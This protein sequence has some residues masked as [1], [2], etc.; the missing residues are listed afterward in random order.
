[1]QDLEFRQ[2]IERLKLRSPIEVIVGERISELKKK[3]ALYQARCPF[4]EER[5]PSFTVDPR[6][7][8]WHCWGACGE[9]G[10]VIS[11]VE[12]FD[13]VSFMDAVRLLAQ[14]AGEELPDSMF[15]RRSSTDQKAVDA[16]YDVLDRA[17]KLYRRALSSDEGAAARAYAE[18]RGLSAETLELFGVGWAPREGNPLLEDPPAGALVTNCFPLRRRSSLRSAA[19]CFFVRFCSTLGPSNVERYMVEKSNAPERSIPLSSGLKASGTDALAP[20]YVSRV[21]ETVL[22]LSRLVV[23]TSLRK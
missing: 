6:R 7:G 2:L 16:R 17:A 20:L 5:T 21:V 11:F 19:A 14:Q 3:G 12:R 8:T 18:G 23:K 4:H 13:G 22:N 9:G 1:M 10:D 15:K